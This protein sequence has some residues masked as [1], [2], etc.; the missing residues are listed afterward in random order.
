MAREVESWGLWG[1]EG[2][3]GKSPGKCVRVSGHYQGGSS[4]FWCRSVAQ[5]GNE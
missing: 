3:E 4:V 5:R 1:A 2:C